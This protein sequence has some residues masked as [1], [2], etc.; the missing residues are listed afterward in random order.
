MT[1]GSTSP[2]RAS[3]NCDGVTTVFP[4]PIQAYQNTDLTVIL[5]APAS[6]GSTQTTLTLNSDYSLTT[7][8]TLQPP[9]WTLTTLAATPYAAGYTLQAFINPVQ[10]QQTQYVQGQAFPSA[11]LQQNV[12]RLTQMV[13][14]LQDQVSR[15]ARAPDGDVSPVMLLP[16]AASRALTYQA[17]DANGNAIVVPALPGSNITP[18]SLGAVLYPTLAGETGVINQYYP[19]HL[20]C[21]PHHLFES[22]PRIVKKPQHDRRIQFESRLSPYCN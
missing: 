14:R 13:Q 3:Y 17:F 9:A 10:E 8:G 19:Y 18:A 2:A 21:F 4:V 15:A 11:A 5:T 20:V 16:P 6:A 12:D 1:I 22:A 7:S